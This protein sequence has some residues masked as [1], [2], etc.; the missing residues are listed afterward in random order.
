MGA[1]QIH[2]TRRAAGHTGKFINGEGF[3]SNGKSGGN[4]DGNF[5]RAVRRVWGGDS[6]ALQAELLDKID[7]YPFETPSN[8]TKMQEHARKFG[9]ELEKM[10][11]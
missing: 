1:G 7:S 8:F 3:G 10:F 5:Y 11:M 2:Q 6:P 4:S 9:V